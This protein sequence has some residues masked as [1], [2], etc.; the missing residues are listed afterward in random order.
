MLLEDLGRFREKWTVSHG[1]GLASAALFSGDVRQPT[2]CILYKGWLAG[3][4]S[5]ARRV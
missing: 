1:P 3:D 4:R 5:W 2:C